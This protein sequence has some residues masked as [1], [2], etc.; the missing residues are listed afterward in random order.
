MSPPC[1]SYLRGRPARRALRSFYP[2]HV[3]ICDELP[4]RP[5]AGLRR[6]RRHLHRLR[7]LLVVL[8][9]LGRARPPVR[10]RHGRP[11]SDSARTASSSRWRATTATC[12]STSWRAASRSSGSSR[13]RTSPTAA[14]EKG[15]P[16]EVRRSS[17]SGPAPRSP[18][19]TARP[20]SSS[21]TTSSPTSRTSSTSS[22]G[23]RALV[24]DDGAGLAGV[25]APAAADRGPAVRHDL[26]RALLLPHAAHR[27]R[28]RWPRPASRSSTSRSCRPTVARCASWRCPWRRR[29][30]SRR[31]GAEGAGGRG[32]RRAAH[33]RGPRRL[34]RGGPRHQGDLL[35]V[36]DR[37]RPGRPVGRRVRRSRQGQ[38]A[39]EPLRHPR[40][41]AAVHGRPQPA[42]ARHVP[43]RD[44]HPDP[45]AGAAR[46]GAPRL[47]R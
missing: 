41:P 25:P 30:A 4:A 8:D 35:D 23:L 26:P 15:I 14:R 37:G 36:P 34:R 47:H 29:R 3:R 28:P 1:E 19:G 11:R 17:A 40:G 9:D 16:T 31:S 24:A 7:L 33:R 27:Q 43:A 44:A 2:L 42:Q 32:G 46:R 45:R 22:A 10:R 39:A 13:R 38:H 12:C 6:G 18:H 5:A 21:A 20:T